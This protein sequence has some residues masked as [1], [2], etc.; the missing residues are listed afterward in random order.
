MKQC[1]LQNMSSRNLT[2]ILC[3]VWQLFSL[4]IATIS[5]M[6]YSNLKAINWGLPLAAHKLN[7]TP[8]ATTRKTN[9]IKCMAECGTTK[10]CFAI[11][12][13]PSKNEEKECEL[14]DVVRHSLSN[15]NFVVSTGW[16]Y[17]GP[18]V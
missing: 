8:I 6:K 12:L 18:K 3:I 17:I 2:L 14:L 1:A 4:S 16:T 15:A 11:N 10:G 7:V 13:G 5:Y 9:H